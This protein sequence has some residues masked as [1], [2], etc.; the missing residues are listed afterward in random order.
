MANEWK[1][2]TRGGAFGYL[3]FI[4]L[5]KY[6]GI[7]AA[8]IFLSL[9]V[10]YFIP[11]AP[12][13]TASSWNYARRIIKLNI[14]KSTLFLFCNYYR[15]GQVLIDKIAVGNGMGNKYKF[16]FDNYGKFIEQLDADSGA[17]I[18]GA[19]VGNWEIGTPFFEDYGKK[20]N[21]A[22]YDAEYRRIKEILEN[23]TGYTDYKIIAVNNDNLE[24]VFNIVS[25]L[26]AKEY[27]CFQG[28]RYVNQEK[29]L[30]C[31]FMGKPA[32]F[33][34][35]VFILASRM[36]VPVIF[37]FA[38][39][40]PKRTYRFHFSI[41]QQPKIQRGSGIKPE[42]VLLEQYVNELEKIVK[43]YPEQWFNYYKFWN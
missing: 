2:R 37:Y 42:Q 18:I 33:P 7:T 4:G 22:L 25:A 39:R 9:V 30:T 14:F 32:K 26:D 38:M 8:Y 6:L 43:K 3:F 34:A 40:E 31:D 5:I 36:R 11:F 27:V 41:I 13:A 19:H 15:F 16:N 1:G 17:I 12:K 21:I 20:I 23:N 10:V 28:D 24:H 29:V 35:G